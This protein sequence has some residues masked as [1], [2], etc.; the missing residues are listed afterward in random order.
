MKFISKLKFKLPLVVL[1]LLIVPLTI[2]GIIS[3]NKTEILEKA[4]IQKENIE[5]VSPKYEKIFK[6]YENRL[7][8]M[9][10]K[11]EFQVNQVNPSE[12]KESYQNMPRVNDPALTNYYEDFLSEMVVDDTFI[13]NL[14]IGTP[15]GALYLHEIDPEADLKNYD[16]TT[17]DWYQLAI[18]AKNQVAWTDPYIDAASGNSTIT[19]SKTIKNDN[20]EI[21]AVA[22]IDFEMSQLATMIRK[23]ILTTT[24]ITL[25]VAV[26][27][28]MVIFL[29]LIRS[30]LVNIS[31]VKNEMNRLAEGD[32]TG[33]KVIVK[34]KDEFVELADSVNKMKSNLYQ[35]IEHLR[36]VTSS[37]QKQSDHLS[38]SSE[39]VSEG[40]E[41]VA[42]TME[43]LSS[44]AESQSN[45]AVDLATAMQQ[46][47]QTV[48]QATN[49]SSS[50]A[51]S[52]DEVIQLSEEG[53]KQLHLSVD[54]MQEIYQL[55]QDSFNKVK[56]LD[57][58]SME[59]EK[60]VSVIQDIA[61]QTNL[62]ALNAAI[63]AAR[64]G[65]EGKGFAVVADEVRKLAEQVSRSITDITTI[66][67]SI[68]T[69]SN[70]VAHS[71]EAGYS[72]VE[73]GS[74]QI[75]KTGQ[76]FQGI[77][78]S[79]TSMVGK[80]QD[81]ANDLQTI[82]TNSQKMYTSVDEIAAISEQ[83]AA[84]I[85]E[86]A[87]SAEETNSSMEEVAKSAEQLSELANRLQSQVDQFK[88]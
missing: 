72:A 10:E 17:R 48:T 49:N 25:G 88:L 26:V 3:Y 41:Q 59:I 33:E 46:Y 16:P 57:Q 45:H 50:V 29:F 7:N 18:N 86:T 52:S 4:I 2:V 61:E 8:Q 38:N 47:N 64:A 34:S 66:V 28:A 27:V 71:L 36:D 63:E 44:G 40:S 12:P 53:A 81:I 32:L 87:A 42:A 39:Q 22:A 76:A 82:A 5:A 9:T 51:K 19:L 65:E 80:V 14:Y 35:M 1:I 60:I 15:E 69:E 23:D 77:N 75:K 6:E 74:S 21:V 70:Q 67:Q 55:V 37:V 78:E 11:D 31:T 85:E 84:G 13:K 30:L 83:S 24:F 56:G 58:Q 62:L 20:D 43:E 68:Q 73:K 79:I 54:Q